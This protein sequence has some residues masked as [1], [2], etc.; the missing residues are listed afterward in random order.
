LSHGIYIIAIIIMAVGIFLL[1]DNILITWSLSKR[2]YIRKE[3]KSNIK[4]LENW[5]D[6]TP[7]ASSP[8]FHVFEII[9]KNRI[10]KMDNEIYEAIAFLRNITAIGHGKRTSSDYIIQKLAEQDGLLKP[11][12]QKMLSFLRINR[13]EE[14]ISFFSKKVGSKISK[15]FAKL[16]IQWD[17]IDPSELT[18]TLLSYGKNIKDIRITNQKRRDEIISD[19]I[20]L[21]VV[22]NI[23]II[24]VNFIYVAYFIDQREMLQMFI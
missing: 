7:K 24:F 6:Y 4:N 21:P 14:A 17:Q 10:Q 18:E 15:D 12:Y 20:Y 2:A 11:I 23:L 13:K 19:L 9:K 8:L 1:K 5:Y 3:L 22:L 16:L